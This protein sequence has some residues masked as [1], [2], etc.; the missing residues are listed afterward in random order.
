MSKLRDGIHLRSYA[1]TNPLQ[2]YINEGYDMFEALKSKISHEVT[3]YCLHATVHVQKKE[4]TENKEA[5]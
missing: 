3:N 5:E 1:Q 4:N 2:A